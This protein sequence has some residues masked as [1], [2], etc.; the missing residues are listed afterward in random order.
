[1]EKFETPIALTFPNGYRIISSKD[2]K[3]REKHTLLQDSF[4][5]FPCVGKLPRM[6]DLTNAIGTGW[7]KGMI[8]VW[9]ERNGPMN[10]IY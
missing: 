10:Q 1:M 2:K 4:H 9:I 3:F 5:L 8:A 6:I 7:E